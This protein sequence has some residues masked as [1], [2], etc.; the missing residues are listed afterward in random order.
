MLHWQGA[1]WEFWR[2]TLI[3]GQVF[4]QCYIGRERLINSEM[5]LWWW[6]QGVVVECSLE[7][8]WELCCERLGT[9]MDCYV[10]KR[11]WQVVGG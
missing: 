7:C 2:V 11:V 6:R 10:S 3:W 9:Q 5:L 8:G 4:L 1:A